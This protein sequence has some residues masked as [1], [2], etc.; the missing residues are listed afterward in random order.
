MYMRGFPTSW[1][2]LLLSFAIIVS[3]AAN[4]CDTGP[5]PITFVGESSELTKG[6]KAALEGLAEMRVTHQAV[7]I[8]F[9]GA[10]PRNTREGALFKKRLQSVRTF[11]HNNGVPAD[12]VSLIWKPQ[13][14]PRELA[15]RD[16]GFRPFGTA[17]LSIGCHK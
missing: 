8:E 2:I 13:Q 16:E 3:N 11:L 4:A 17:K 14:L 9:F 10:N 1:G 12:Q 6:S 7:L 15:A 5:F